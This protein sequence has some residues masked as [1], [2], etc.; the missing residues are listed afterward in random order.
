VKLINP[1]IL[2]HLA[3]AQNALDMKAEAKKTAQEAL[4]LSGEK[5]PYYAELKKI[6]E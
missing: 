3:T 5:A 2:F 6:A 1:E 4:K